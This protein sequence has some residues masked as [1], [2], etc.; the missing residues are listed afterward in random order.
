[1][2]RAAAL[3]PR[4]LRFA[5][6]LLIAL[7]IGALACL[8]FVG[9][10][11][12]QADTLQRGDLIVVLAGARLDRWLEAVDLFKEGW[13]P[14]IV[15]SPG[16][17]SELEA[18]LRREGL[19]LPREG[20]IARDAVLSLGIPADAVTVMPG[21]VDNTAAEAASLHR[22][23]PTGSVHRIIV[24]TS[25]YH[26]RRAGYAFRRE[27]TG[28]G[29]EIVARGSRYTEARPARWWTRRDDI[30]FIMNE[31]PKYF[32]YLLGVGE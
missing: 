24:V 19:K 2:P 21:G 12:S 7:A 17:V 6:I 29:I 28:S 10:F 18:K 31:A 27:F 26:V 14:K 16:Q 5:G 8:P 11:L 22:M 23:L 9:R 25:T 30:R 1:M 3:R 20:E 15:L 13:A 4:L 32:V